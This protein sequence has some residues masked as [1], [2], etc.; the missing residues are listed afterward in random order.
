MKLRAMA[1]GIAAAAGLFA[2]PQI[3]QAA[4]WGQATGNVNLRTCP[5]TQCGKITV[6][7]A[8]A[9]VWVYGPTSGWYHLRFAG[10]DGY[11]SANYIAYGYAPGPRPPV[12]VGRPPPPNWGYWRR[13]WWDTRYGAWYDGRRWWYNNR[14]YNQPTFYFGFG[15]GN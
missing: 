3:A 13:P 15:I 9:Q 7:P 6:V 1:I 12:Y 5:S 11:A 10:Y 8:G 4:G 2:I 14:W